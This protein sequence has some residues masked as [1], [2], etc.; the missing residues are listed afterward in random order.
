M[1]YD[2]HL[3]FSG[4]Y[5]A[6]RRLMKGSKHHGQH[7]LEA[8]RFYSNKPN[9]LRTLAFSEAVL[10]SKCLLRSAAL[11]PED[12]AMQRAPPFLPPL[13]LHSLFMSA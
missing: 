11:N 4:H 12:L 7:G 8:D 10:P 3:V 13:G 1:S 5:I 2:L 9:S 6:Q